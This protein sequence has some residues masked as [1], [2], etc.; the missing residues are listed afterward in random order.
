MMRASDGLRR[1]LVG[2]LPQRYAPAQTQ[3]LPRRS[4]IGL[5]LLVCPNAL[6]RPLCANC[7][8]SWAT[9]SVCCSELVSCPPAAA[10]ETVGTAVRANKQ[11]LAAK[12]RTIGTSP[13]LLCRLLVA[14]IPS[15][16]LFDSAKDL[17]MG[18]KQVGVLCST[19]AASRDSPPWLAHTRHVHAELAGITIMPQ[20]HFEGVQ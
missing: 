18:A 20:R 7:I 1:H 8:L 16:D 5:Q 15:G 13:W 14:L 2:V 17:F 4:H 10:P 11:K 3:D 12:T 9:D 19:L 6:Q